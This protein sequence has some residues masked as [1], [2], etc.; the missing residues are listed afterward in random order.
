[1]PTVPFKICVTRSDFDFSELRNCNM[2]IAILSFLYTL[3]KLDALYAIWIM[4]YHK[5]LFLR[6]KRP[7]EVFGFFLIVLWN[8][9]YQI[10]SQI[11]SSYLRMWQD[12][13]SQIY[14]LCRWV[15]TASFVGSFVYT[16]FGVY[17]TDNSLKNNFFNVKINTYQ[18]AK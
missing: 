16:R 2:C 7:W 8:T 12:D 18:Y 4:S 1:M 3:F 5:K 14:K 13:N 17:I 6:K 15:F 11:Y 9:K 10:K